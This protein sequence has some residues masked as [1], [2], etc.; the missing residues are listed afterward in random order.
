[1]PKRVLSSNQ[2]SKNKSRAKGSL[3]RREQG[4]TTGRVAGLVP[5]WWQKENL[6]KGLVI[7]CPGCHSFYYEEHW[8]SWQNTKS[9]AETLRRGGVLSESL[10][11]EC[12]Y[13]KAGHGT[14]G[15][16]GEVL[17][18]NLADSDLK[19]EILN[20]VR[21]IGKRAMLRDPEDRIIKIE[22]KGDTVRVTTTENQ[23]AV[24][25]GKQVARSHKGGELEIKFSETD[26]PA[27]V[28]W[29]KK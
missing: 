6:G 25:I 13:E 15:Y 2:V 26:Y 18:K 22:D 28:V 10:C 17:L 21:N 3:S 12:T 27:R 23:L 19:I 20:T 7:Y 24:S 1:M 11:P 16:E 29:T 14:T 5:Q 8:H 4:R 9:L